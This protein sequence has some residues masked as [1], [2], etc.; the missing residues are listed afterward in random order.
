L[1]NVQYMK[2]QVE[3]TGGGLDNVLMSMGF[4][5]LDLGMGLH[6]IGLG[7]VY[8]ILTTLPSHELHSLQYVSDRFCY[9]LANVTGELLSGQPTT[10][11]NCAI[12]RFSQLKNQITFLK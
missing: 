8:S 2:S 6:R 4:N 5:C 1:Y 10:A 11:C 9:D 7:T 12:F 3:G